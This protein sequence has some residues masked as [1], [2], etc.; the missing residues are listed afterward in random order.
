MRR[1]AARFPADS[2]HWT[3]VVTKVPTLRKSISDRKLGN[4]S[5]GRLQRSP[6]PRMPGCR[7]D[8]L[9]RTFRPPS[10]R[11]ESGNT[12]YA[13]PLKRSSLPDVPKYFPADSLFRSLSFRLEFFRTLVLLYCMRPAIHIRHETPAD[14]PVLRALIDASSRRL[15][16]DF[17]HAQ[18]E[19]AL[20]TVF[21]V[22]SQ[23][24]RGRNVFRRR[25]QQRQIQNK[26][27]GLW[28]LEQTQN[29]LRQ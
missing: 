1:N 5:A 2:M 14:I 26:P 25:I 15:Q 17:T 9:E 19:N 8:A 13:R 7:L 20:Q 6:I 11:R 18:I 4:N 22:D 16:E 29:A 27:R 23:A 24:D 21:A 3:L 10:E 12:S 28:R